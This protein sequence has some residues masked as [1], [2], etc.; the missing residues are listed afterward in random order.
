[1]EEFVDE[2][3]ARTTIEVKEEE[4]IKVLHG[5]NGSFTKVTTSSKRVTRAAAAAERQRLAAI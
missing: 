1:M 4:V 2:A 3:L 5:T